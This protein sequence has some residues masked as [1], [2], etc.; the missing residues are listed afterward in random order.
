M[1]FGAGL[2]ALCMLSLTSYAL[3]AGADFGAGFWDLVAGGPRQGQARRS[4][5]AHSIGPV[6]EANHVWAIFVLVIAWTAFPPFFAAIT[7][8]LYVPLTAVAIG[9]IARGS[10]FAFRKVVTEVWQQRLFGATFAFSSVVTP[11]FWG[12]IA[13]AIAS[14]RVPPGLA[15]GDIVTSWVNPTSLACGVLAVGVC[16]YLSALYLTADARRGAHQVLAEYFRRQGLITGVVVGVL[17]FS[18]IA[19]VAKDAPQLY[20]GLTHRGIALVAVSITAGLLSLALLVRRHYIAVRAT[21]A[22]AVTAVLWAWGAGQYPQLLPGLDINQASA[23][24]STLQAT[25]VTAA[26]GLALLV[27]SM[28]WLLTLFQ[29]ETRARRG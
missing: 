29:R 10:A 25:A 1:T 13:G 11:F 22:T 2:L 5:I 8:T 26:I 24:Q 16:A 12:A 18:A 20:H 17:A 28:A 4:L 23:P 21:A 6:W 9:I 15:A 14:G 7:S 19:V 3:L 27:P